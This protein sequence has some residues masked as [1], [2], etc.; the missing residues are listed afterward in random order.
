MAI[1]SLLIGAAAIG[2][3]LLYASH[4]DLR[5]RRVPFR[6]WYPMIA[7]GAPCTA[8]FYAS[9]FGTAPSRALLLL[10]LSIVL[11][12]AFH[13]FGR[14]GFIGGAD[15]W[16][17]VFITLLLPAFPATPLLGDTLPGFF[18]LPM[19]VNA[20]VAAL[21]A[22][23]GIY[24]GNVKRRAR[25]PL[26]ARLRGYPVTVDEITDGR[27]FGF[28]M[29]DISDEGGELRRRFL[30]LRE[31]IGGMVRDTRLY[32]RELRLSPEEYTAELALIRR[33]SPVWIAAGIPFIVPLTAGFFATLVL[34]DT[35][36]LSLAPA[37]GG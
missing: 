12:A 30:T 25:G 9:L 15:A 11:A 36:F 13:L 10:A 7:I 24:L 32:T 29:E 37:G 16:A 4:R 33:A 28:L 21:L 31:S 18:P 2:V 23:V 35:L 5:E 17:L 14:L 3:T 1:N 8:W 27:V 19:L 6:T 20:G 22:P 34:G 26:I